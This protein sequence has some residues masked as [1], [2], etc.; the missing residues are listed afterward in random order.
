M[1]KELPVVTLAIN[2]LT[3]L[4][5]HNSYCYLP[6]QWLPLLSASGPQHTDHVHDVIQ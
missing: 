2:E 1:F 5:T 3:L 6:I 4:A